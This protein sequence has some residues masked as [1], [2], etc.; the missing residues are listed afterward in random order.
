MFLVSCDFE[1]SVVWSFYWFGICLGL[2]LEL[3]VKFIIGG[4]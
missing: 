4:I 2:C 1:V 3:K